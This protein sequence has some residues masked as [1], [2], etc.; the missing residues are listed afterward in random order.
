MA[1]KVFVAFLAFMVLTAVFALGLH[2]LGYYLTAIHERP[3]R[4][5]HEALKPS[6]PYSLGLG[7]VGACMIVIGVTIYSTRKRVRALWN[8]GKLSRWLGL[9]IFLC[10]LGPVLVIFHT[11]FKASGVAGISLWTM[12]SVVA[13]GLVGRFLYVQIPRNILGKELS[14]AQISGELDRLEE[15]LTSTPHGARLARQVNM[16][17][18]IIG[19][20]ADLWQAVSSFMRLHSIRKYVRKSVRAMISTGTISRHHAR[21]LSQT[22]TARASLLQKTVVLGQVG[23]LFYYWH[24]VHIPFSIIMFITLAAHVVVSVL[25]G[26]TWIF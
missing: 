2:G 23:R 20:P 6:A 18:A 25:A 14:A 5:E 4:D 16:A 11:T 1:H 7:I 17:L 10:L 26:Y 24:A 21:Q 3:F 8:V 15:A 22:A 13:S 12:L 19:K 9:H